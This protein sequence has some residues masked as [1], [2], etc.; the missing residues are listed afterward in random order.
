[1][2]ICHVSLC[3]TVEPSEHRW[4]HHWYLLFRSFQYTCGRPSQPPVFDCFQYANTE[5]SS[6]GEKWPN[7]QKTNTHKQR[8][9][10]TE[11][12]LIIDVSIQP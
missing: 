7:T 1:M 2:F 10:H 3:H 8:N 4:D 11:I 9:Q 5:I 6:Q 12:T